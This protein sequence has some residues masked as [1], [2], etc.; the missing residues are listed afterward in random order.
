MRVL[1]L[2]SSRGIFGAE[3]VI[4]QLA[5]ECQ[6]RFPVAVAALRDAREPHTELL[7][8]AAAAGLETHA[9]DCA[10]K[11]DPRTVARVA[12]LCRSGRWDILH[13]HDYKTIVY[14]IPAAKLGGARLVVTLHGDT[15][16][17]A[18][19]S[20]YEQASFQ[21]LRLA[22]KVATVS[23]EIYE[24]V[25]ALVPGKAVWVPNGI[26]TDALRRKVTPGRDLRAEL[27]VPPDH[28]LAV[29]VGRLSIEKA[30]VTLLEAAARVPRLFVAIAGTGPLETELRAR[31]EALGLG[32]RARLLGGRDDVAD[33]YASADIFVHPSLREGLPMAILEAAALSAPTIASAVGEIPEVLE[34]C[35]VALPP[36]GDVVA[37]ADA[38]ARATF[39]PAA[40]RAAGQRARARVDAR[41]SAAAMATRYIDEVYA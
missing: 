30:H 28:T 24:R 7:D 41:Y 3:N 33:L 17:N 21:A 6:R 13:V 8:R 15:K 14:G 10:G 34:G 35:A 2:R 26:D 23:Q 9:I 31:I 4:L 18:S 36:P 32:A 22:H 27:G 11:V 25:R 5:G 39:D 20:R 12:R 29:A 38:L 40:A 1:H 19:V 37:L 16:E